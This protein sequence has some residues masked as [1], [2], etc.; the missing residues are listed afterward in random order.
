[1]CQVIRSK[2]YLELIVMKLS[3]SEQQKNE[4]LSAFIDAEQS[5]T[6]TAQIVDALLSDSDFKARFARA[7]L[8]NDSLRG[9][10]HES[11]LHNNLQ[12][13]VSA[14][15][16][17]LPAHYVDDAV[18]LQPV[19]TEDVTQSHWFRQ[20]LGN[21]VF[22]GVSVAASV[23]FATLLTIQH[24]DPASSTSINSFNNNSLAESAQPAPALIQGPPVLAANLASAASGSAMND[25]SRQNLKQQYRWIE[26]DPELSR[27]VR[28]YINEH[29]IHR[30][31]YRLQPKIQAVSYQISE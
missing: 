29:E 16:D 3:E 21:K 13:R 18:D 14:A 31:A 8:L 25:N 12:N 5:D 24:F 27:Q 26:A 10:I 7:Q 30:A 9:Q 4:M 23:M 6:E 22:S 20:L 1:M 15:L 11:L 19:H 28:Q 2:N 17:D